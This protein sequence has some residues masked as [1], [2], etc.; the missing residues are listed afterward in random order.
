[1]KTRHFLMKA[2]VTDRFLLVGTHV[3]L[4]WLALLGVTAAAT[5]LPNPCL[6]SSVG[7]AS[8]HVTNMGT[9]PHDANAIFPY[10]GTWHIMHQANWTDWAH[11][12]STDMV[13]WT[14]IPS[15]LAPNGAYSLHLAFHLAPWE[16]TGSISRALSVHR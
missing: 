2:M 16:T 8:F 7:V 10:K 4:L 5:P 13:R 6:P 14:R 3:M 1:M 9:G 11:L 12:V 15:A